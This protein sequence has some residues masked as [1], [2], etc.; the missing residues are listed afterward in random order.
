L[1]AKCRL[2]DFTHRP[3]TKEQAE[4]LAAAGG[5]WMRES[6]GYTPTAAEVNEWSL[7]GM[8]HDAINQSVCVKA[9]C[10][11]TGVPVT[12]PMCG[13]HGHIWQ[14]PE[15]EKMHEEWESIDPPEGD[16]FQLWEDCSEGSPVSPVFK[17]LDDLCEWC[18]T[19]ATTFGSSTATAEEWKKMLSPGGLVC[20]T[21]GN[22]VFL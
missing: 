12:C 8:A 14:S 19:G 6:N 21:E 1:V 5:Y 2:L 9:R 3:R 17:T 18:V 11:R 10:K 16:G 13:G 20:H 4:A 15:I 7:A 22:M